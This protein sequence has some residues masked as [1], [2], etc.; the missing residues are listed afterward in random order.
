MHWKWPLFF[1]FPTLFCFKANGNFSLFLRSSLLELCL[2]EPQDMISSSTS[3]VFVAQDPVLPCCGCK[4]TKHSTNYSISS[5][6][7]SNNASLSHLPVFSEG[8][9]WQLRSHSLPI[10]PKKQPSEFRNQDTL[11]PTSQLS[12]FGKSKLFQNLAAL[13]PSQNSSTNSVFESP[14]LCHQEKTENERRRKSHLTL[15]HGPN[16]VSRERPGFSGW[17]PVQLSPLARWELEGH[18]AWKVCTLREQTVPLSVRES[19]AMLNDLKEAQG[20]VPEPEKPQIQVSKPIHQRSKQSIS[21]KSPN[22]PSFQLHV[23]IGVESGSRRTETKISQSFFPGKQSQPGNGPQILESRPLVTSLGPSPPKSLGVDI[24]Q[25]ETTVLQKEPKHVLELSIEQRVIGLPEKRIH[26]HKTQLTNVELTPKPQYQVTDRIKV[27][28]LALL[29]VMDSMGMIPESHSEVTESV[30]L[31][32]QP[33]DEVEK[34]MEPMKKVSVSPKSSYQ[35]TESVEVTPSPQYQ[36]MELKMIS[37]PQNQVTSPGKMSPKAQHAVVETVEMTIGPEHEVTESVDITSKPQSQVIEPLKFP[38]EP[39]CQ[40]TRSLERTSSPSQQVMDYMKVTP[41]ALLQAMDFM[42]IIPPAQPH[43]IHSGDSQSQI[44]NLTPGATQPDGLTSSSPTTIGPPE[45]VESVGLPSEPPHKVTESVG[46]VPMSS[47]QSIHSLKV[48]P[49]TLESPIGMII[50]PQ[51]RV[52]E[53]QDLSSRPIPQVKEPLELIPSSRIQVQD[54]V[55]MIPQPYHEGTET[56]ALTPGPPHQVM[57]SSRLISQHQT[58]ESSEVSPK[59]NHQIIENMRLASDTWPQMKKSVELNPSHHQIMGPLGTW[60]Q[61]KKSVELNLSHHQIIG[62]LGTVPKSLGQSTVS[63]KP[64]HQVAESAAMTTTS[65]LPNVDYLGA[66]P[67]PQLKVVDSMK[68]SSGL[69]NVKSEKLTLGQRIQNIKSTDRTT[70]LIPQR[71]KYGELIPTVNSIELVSELQQQIVKSDELAPIPQT[72]SGHSVQIA[73]GSQLQGVRSI[74]LTLGTQQQSERSTELAPAPQLQNGKLKDLTSSSQ[75]QGLEH[76]NLALPPEFADIKGVELTLRQ[77]QEDRK[78]MDLA[79]KPWLQDKRSEERAPVLLLKDVKIPQMVECR[80]LIPETQ[81]EDMKYEEPISG[82]H[83]QAVKSVELNLKPEPQATEPEGLTPWHQALES[84]GMIAEPRYPGTEAELTSNNRHYRKE[85]VELKQ[86]SSGNTPG[87]LSQ[88]S[89]CMQMNSVALQGTRETMLQGVKPL[90]TPVSQHTIRESPELV[91]GSEMQGMNPQ[92]LNPES[93]GIKF[94]HL[95]LGP[96][97]EFINS[98]ELISEPQFQSVKYVP[99]TPEPQPKSTKPEKLT[100]GPLMHG[101]KFVDLTVP[102]EESRRLIPDT[103]LHAESRKLTMEPHLQAM[104]SVGLTSRPWHQDIASTEL[105]SEIWPHEEE[106]VKLTP[107]QVME[108]A[109]MMPRTYLK[110]ISEMVPGPGYQDTEAMSLTSEPL[111]QK[112]IGQVIESAGMTLKPHLQVTEPS[113]IPLR[114]ENTETMWLALFQVENT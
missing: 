64:L 105:A 11:L 47:H 113:E 38:P 13:S 78:S 100:L 22:Y 48:T 77:L 31:F 32:P 4:K 23:N 102:L 86:S 63:Q 108:T 67:M 89:E 27:T 109:E 84:L 93:Q 98:K 16:S 3:S 1:P 104:K 52:V 29:Q 7:L 82:A 90:E 42:G 51:S 46:I 45:V 103:H 85:S 35:V 8:T 17:A 25:E 114:S 71:V 97:S 101:N 75:L 61:M 91:P 9:T 99:L 69:Q 72:K 30:G 18:M 59:K 19:W 92:I 12:E 68:L 107:Q 5:G 21:N 111:T 10:L 62:P 55:G 49:V 28:P 96:Y 57:E 94:V 33:P 70:G 110:K 53:T 80:R 76:V 95:N 58:L 66:Q 2:R 14:A 83:I 39:I 37:R 15:D 112:Q 87:P 74:Q 50:A 81:V 54:P 60:P 65:L 24:N 73:P 88:T 43:V 26:Y 34:P 20:G 56:M 44:P 40:K 41:V 6:S 79:L 36:M 106:S